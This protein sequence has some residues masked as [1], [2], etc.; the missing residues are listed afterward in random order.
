MTGLKVS[1]QGIRL[2]IS[3]EAWRRESYND[4]YG[5]WT[6]GVGHTRTKPKR[7]QRISDGEVWRLFVEDLRIVEKDIERLVK[8][9]LE[10]HEYD[11]LVSFIFNI[12]GSK[13]KT[14][15]LLRL[16]NENKK[17]EAAAQFARWRMSAGQVSNGLIRRRADEAR[18]FLGEN[19][20]V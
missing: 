13:F 12:G 14:S 5:F 19:I 1:E 7:G 17:Q 16:L 9:R 20:F 11:A 3:H 6:I 10:Q 8:V 4:G 18:T 15:T 2:I